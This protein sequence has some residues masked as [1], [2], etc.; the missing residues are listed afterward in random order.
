MRLLGQPWFKGPVAKIINWFKGRVAQSMTAWRPP[1][2]APAE[3]LS[4]ALGK[5][6]ATRRTALH[7]VAW[8]PLKR[9][10]RLIALSRSTN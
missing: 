5:D 10:Y 7:S 8:R 3:E 1:R 6:G 4:F 9:A 2:S